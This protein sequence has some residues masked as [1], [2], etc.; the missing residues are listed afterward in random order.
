MVNLRGIVMSRTRIVSAIAATITL[1][2]VAGGATALAAGSENSGGSF[3]V[4]YSMRQNDGIGQISDVYLPSRSSR[5]LPLDLPVWF[6][7]C[8][9]TVYRAISNHTH[10][11]SHS[12]GFDHGRRARPPLTA[13]ARALRCP[14]S[15]TSCLPRITP[16]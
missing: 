2:T 14:M 15:M 3:R 12:R 8:R 13:V 16:V 6:Q 1:V 9:L 5:G 7:V 4:D 10:I 11:A